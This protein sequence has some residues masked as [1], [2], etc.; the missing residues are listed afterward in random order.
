MFRKNGLKIK[1]SKTHYYK[2]TAIKKITGVYINRG[3]PKVAHKKHEEIFIL[4][5][6]I[7]KLVQKGV[8]N[9]DDFLNMY[10]LFLKFS[11]NFIHLCEVEYGGDFSEN[12]KKFTHQKYAQLYSSLIHV[13]NIGLERLDNYKGFEKSNLKSKSFNDANTLFKKYKDIESR[14]KSRF[15]LVNQSIRKHVITNRI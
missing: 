15:P 10:G 11:G 13:L 6:E 4:Y 5:K 7:V 2:N 1:R 3:L 12:K 9:I 14:L 8:N